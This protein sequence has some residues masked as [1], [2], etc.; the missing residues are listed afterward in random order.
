MQRARVAMSLRKVR[1]LPSE[2]D[3]ASHGI[4]FAISG[5]AVALLYL[6]VTTALANGFGVAFQ[7]ALA[8]GFAT[9]ITAHFALQRLFVWVHH[10]EFALDMRQQVPRYLTLVALQYG[11]TAAATHLLPDRLGLSV[12]VV[13]LGT[14][15]L[16]VTVNFLIFRSRIF[17]PNPDLP[18]SRGENT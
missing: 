16:V 12:T 3:L 15:V 7:V 6:L 8:I 5:A 10:S 14:T 13:Y 4:R 17:H 2:S 1:A 18:P 9:A 11:A